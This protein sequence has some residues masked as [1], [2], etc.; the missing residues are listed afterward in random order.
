MEINP[1]LYDSSVPLSSV[2][3]AMVKVAGWGGG[4]LLQLP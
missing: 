1:Q 4:G 3:M 2:V